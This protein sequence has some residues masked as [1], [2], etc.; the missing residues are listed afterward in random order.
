MA[1]ETRSQTGDR[2]GQLHSKLYQ[3]RG[4]GGNDPYISSY[5][6]GGAPR[7]R[8]AAEPQVGSQ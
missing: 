8:G 7:G 5:G 3:H 4:G 1:D 2:E 6:P